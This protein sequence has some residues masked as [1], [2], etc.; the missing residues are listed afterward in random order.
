[1]KTLKILF[2]ASHWKVSLINAFQCDKLPIE[3]ICGDS[4]PLAPSFREA[5]RY[6]ILPFFSDPQC[7]RSILD[8]CE[9]EKLSLIHI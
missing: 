7:L 5:D 9:V 2:L 1:M 3:R 8:F 4:D 6:Q